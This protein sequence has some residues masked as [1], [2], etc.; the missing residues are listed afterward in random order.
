MHKYLLLVLVVLTGKLYAQD[1]TIV[2]SKIK[3]TPTLTSYSSYQ[4]SLTSDSTW[5]NQDKLIFGF[6]SEFNKHWSASVAIDMVNHDTKNSNKINGYF[7][8]AKI[9]YQSNKLTVDAGIF[10]LNQYESQTNFWGNRFV[11]KVYQDKYGLGYIADLGIH[12]TY[13]WNDFVSTDATLTTGKSHKLLDY[14]TPYKPA[15][16]VILT[17]VKP[18]TLVAYYDMY[19]ASR[20][21]QAFSFTADYRVNKISATIEYNRKDNFQFVSECAVKG[22]S[23][24][25]NYAVTK[26]VGLFARYDYIK[27]QIPEQSQLANSGG[28]SV[29]S[30]FY[31]RIFNYSRISLNYQNW[32]PSDTSRKKYDWLF[33]NLEVKY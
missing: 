14:R 27:Y 18:L 10:I 21:Q 3:I 23:A 6:V 5:F 26:R 15:F 8:P 30:G 28:N 4:Y 16:R 1:S 29:I 31:V 11:S 17:P 13:K 32:R 7:K 22:I 2:R 24:Y 9:T 25:S 20:K 12:V 33:M 19:G